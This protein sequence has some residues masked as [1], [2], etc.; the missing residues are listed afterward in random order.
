MDNEQKKNRLKA[1]I[2]ILVILLCISIA[3]LAA[4]L[5]YNNF[6]SYKSASVVVPDN[7]ITKETN[8]TNTTETNIKNSPK[9]L[10]SGDN[11]S[12]GDNAL[13]SNPV[14]TSSAAVLTLYN[15]KADDNIP[16]KVENMFPGDSETKYY[17]V[18]VSQKNTLTVRY[19]ADIHNG[20][21]KLAEVLKI[22]IN[23]LST[24]EQLYDGLIRDMPESLDHT[25]ETNQSTVSELYYE[26]TAYLDTSVGNDYQNKK[27]V[28]DFKWWT[29]DSSSLGDNPYTGDTF[30][31]LLWISAAAGSL[32]IFVL[33]LAKRPKEENDEK[34]K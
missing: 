13:V 33:L 22:R 24:G 2:I 25:L 19:H 11:A 4:I 20:Y 27:L 6:F 30:N 18:R 17:C 28:A 29:E 3:A 9:G 32:L 21:E 5:I 10:N 15:M 26:I 23:L 12:S 1:V 14:D 7:I 31:I 8:P 34:H 16:F